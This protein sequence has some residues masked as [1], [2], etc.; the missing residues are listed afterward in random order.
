MLLLKLKSIHSNCNSGWFAVKLL[1]PPRA[2]VK[3]EITDGYSKT[4]TLVTN[5]VPSKTGWWISCL[6]L[7]VNATSK[8]LSTETDFSKIKIFNF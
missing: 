5:C 1:E 6:C 4:V 2:T 3:W 7:E 8:L